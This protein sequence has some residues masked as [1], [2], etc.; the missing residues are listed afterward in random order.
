MELNPEIY[1]SKDKRTGWKAESKVMLGD[2]WQVDITTRKNDR[3][4]L[5][6]LVSVGR[7]ERGF[8]THRL[9]SDYMRYAFNRAGVKCTE[10]NVT[11]QHTEAVNMIDTILADV[12]DHYTRMNEPLPLP[13]VA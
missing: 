9:Y 5:V 11:N 1:V 12:R 2:T 3:G 8:L 6:T 4:A 13:A 10:K 7:I